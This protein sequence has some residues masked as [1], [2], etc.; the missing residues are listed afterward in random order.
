MPIQDSYTIPGYLQI[1][2]LFGTPD[3]KIVPIES[4][5]DVIGFPDV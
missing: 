5:L 4:L 3:E 2:N 1:D